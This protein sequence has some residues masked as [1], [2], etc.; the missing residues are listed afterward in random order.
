MTAFSALALHKLQE[1][2]K[3][4]YLKLQLMLNSMQRV[5]DSFSFYRSFKKGLR[6]R[7]EILRA[8]RAET[9]QRT[10]LT[11]WARQM[12]VEVRSKMIERAR[13]FSLKQISVGALQRNKQIR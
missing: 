7:Q 10:V 9:Q 12:G 5:F 3:L 1:E 4:G 2:E 8:K 11:C 6:E 13:E